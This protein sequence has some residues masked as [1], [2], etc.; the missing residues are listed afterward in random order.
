[1]ILR[2]TLVSF[3]LSAFSAQAIDVNSNGVDDIF[4]AQYPAISGSSSS[5]DTDGDGL[6]NA[7]E[8]LALTD[9]TDPTDCFKCLPLAETANAFVIKWPSKEGLSYQVQHSSDGQ[10]WNLV[11][12]QI[13]GT[14]A[15]L[16]STISKSSLPASAGNFFSV[17]VAGQIDTDDDGIADWAEE[18]LG[19]SSTDSFSVRSAANGGDTQHLANLLTGA[20][21]SGGLSGT[22]SPGIPSDEHASR[23]L[24]QTTFGPRM[25]DIAALQ[26][27]GANGYEKWI[28]QQLALPA[29]YQS[30]YIS[31]IYDLWVVDEADYDRGDGPFGLGV[32]RDR[33]G[34][35]FGS[36]W[37]PASNV[38]AIWMRN[39]INGKDQLRQRVAW[40]L[41]QIMVIS[42]EDT[43]LERA[44]L[45][46]AHYY[47]R[48][49]EHSF[50]NFDDLLT[51]VSQNP[52]MGTYLTFLNNRKPDPAS[53][54]IPDENYAREIMQLFSIGLFELN[55]D[56]TMIHD[57]NGVAQESYDNE[58]IKA[59][60][61][62]F[63][64]YKLAGAGFGT[65]S[66]FR[67]RTYS[68]QKMDWQINEKDLEPK[69]FLKVRGMTLNED[70][71]S[72]ALSWPAKEGLTYMPMFMGTNGYWVETTKVSATSDGTLTTTLSK[73]EVGESLSIDQFQIKHH[74]DMELSQGS[75][76][77][78]TF[79]ETSTEYHLTWPVEAGND[80]MVRYRPAPNQPFADL[81]Q[82]SPPTTTTRTQRIRKNVVGTGLT[83]D[84]FKIV[85]SI[86]DTLTQAAL[87]AAF[88]S[89]LD[90]L[91]RVLT[92]HPNTAPFMAK[93]LIKHLVTSN[94]SPEYVARV[95]TVFANNGSGVSGDLGATVKAVLL[96]PEARGT[97]FLI[98]PTWGKLKEPML[99]VTQLARFYDAGRNDSYD[100]NPTD[101][102]RF[103]TNL[104]WWD[105]RPKDDL[106]QE[107]FNAP[108]VF[109]FFEPDYSHP[110]ILRD[111][112]L[113]SPAF[114]ILSPVTALTVPNRITSYTNN[115]F[116]TDNEGQAT[117]F[118]NDYSRDQTAFNDPSSGPVYVDFGFAED[119]FKYILTLN[120]SGGVDYEIQ[121][122]PLGSSSFQLLDNISSGTSTIFNEWVFKNQVGQ[123]LTKDDFRL[124]VA[125]GATQVKEEEY[126]DR[127]NL[128]FANGMLNAESRDTLT[129]VMEQEFGTPV[130]A[131]AYLMTIAPNTAIQK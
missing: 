8:A 49:I 111:A 5:D 33:H 103:D 118:E 80:Y 125:S 83:A 28:D 17:K 130:K 90:T 124:A 11:G 119:Q 1:M 15:V 23:F 108:S 25:S 37:L 72:Y 110:G 21:P 127:L 76:A 128:L 2:F 64:G 81:V 56:G 14:G 89:E 116:H 117:P 101:T 27:L 88:Q 43:A 126:A 18:L 16:S 73:L 96:D 92:G 50:G 41:S 39:A 106:L 34:Y 97:R 36:M 47:D 3:T 66:Q 58:D 4:E 94:P 105:A 29:S 32:V 13:N 85:I 59:L 115:G 79:L 55:M 91:I 87:Y 30:P 62:I 69:S 54:R 53:G 131:A 114:Q 75:T 61:R 123:G 46:L 86:N 120:L 95:A 51:E 71:A 31:H 57:E 121:Y 98:D 67:D 26:A 102:N 74:I 93:Q 113:E 19:F 99:R 10:V 24:T 60:A 42:A 52:L 77:D 35:N 104:Q 38:D 48:L 44:T 129:K 40:A 100:A 68:I 112:G 70:D 109:N 12:A 78:F 7:A 9:P 63:T 84:D 6:S 22:T 20:N 122:R 82:V 65:T 107:P 45:G